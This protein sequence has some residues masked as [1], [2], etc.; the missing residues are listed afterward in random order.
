MSCRRQ[1]RS[2]QARPRCSPGEGT[3]LGGPAERNAAATARTLAWTRSS[4]SARAW[5]CRTP[6]TGPG[7]RRPRPVARS[8]SRVVPERRMARNRRRPSGSQGSLPRTLKNGGTL[9]VSRKSLQ[10]S[11]SPGPASPPAPWRNASAATSSSERRG[12]ILRQLTSRASPPGPA[13]GA[14]RIR[15]RHGS[16][17]CPSVIGDPGGAR[18]EKEEGPPL[19]ARRLENPPLVA[20]PVHLDDDGSFQAQVPD[21]AVLPGASRRRASPSPRTPRPPRDSR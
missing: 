9:V 20:L 8:V 4:S 15:S 12:T 2:L 16:P 6:R 18:A 17:A 19:S 1:A 7:R 13:R 11:R 14:S 10:I 21:D 5:S 3:G